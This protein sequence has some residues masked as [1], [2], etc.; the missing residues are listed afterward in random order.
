MIQYG[1]MFA[2]TT[3]SHNMVVVM[4]ILVEENIMEASKNALQE[5]VYGLVASI[6]SNI[7]YRDQDEDMIDEEFIR[8]IA[9]GNQEA[10]DKQAAKNKGKRKRTN[11]SQQDASNTDSNKDDPSIVNV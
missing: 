1:P 5:T 4:E 2:L 11:G 9:E 3:V 7:D 10:S 8:M 6:S